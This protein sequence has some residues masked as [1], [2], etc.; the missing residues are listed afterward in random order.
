MMKTVY[1]GSFTC[2]IP[3]AGVQDLTFTREADVCAVIGIAGTFSEYWNSAVPSVAACT[4]YIGE[5]F[6][7]KSGIA[8]YFY[9]ETSYSNS[10]CITVHSIV[11]VRG[12]QR[13]PEVRFRRHAA[14]MLRNFS[15]G[16]L[17]RKCT[18]L[19]L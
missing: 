11:P 13:R 17:T 12:V 8:A 9:H 4:L 7:V 1:N 6:G 3:D 2:S 14:P 10:L 18:A 16:H 5:V 19:T 15:C